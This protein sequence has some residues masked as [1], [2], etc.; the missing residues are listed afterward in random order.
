MSAPL[1][2]DGKSTPFLVFCS[3]NSLSGDGKFKRDFSIALTGSPS[4]NPSWETPG[5]ATLKGG[6]ESLLLD[7]LSVIQGTPEAGTACLRIHAYRGVI[8]IWRFAVEVGVGAPRETAAKFTMVPRCAGPYTGTRVLH[9]WHR[10]FTAV[11]FFAF[12]F[13]PREYDVGSLSAPQPRI[14]YEVACSGISP[15]DL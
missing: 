15:R 10:L 14:G 8:T 12:V 11:A 4:Q 2:Q 13:I 5:T 6:G 7:T 9:I 1:V 3:S